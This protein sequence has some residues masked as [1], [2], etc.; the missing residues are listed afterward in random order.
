V[1]GTPYCDIHWQQAGQ[2]L[3]ICAAI[4]NLLKGAAAQAVQLANQYFGFASAQ[5]LG[6]TGGIV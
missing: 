5:G 6:Q 3:I 4:D 2:Q 1:A